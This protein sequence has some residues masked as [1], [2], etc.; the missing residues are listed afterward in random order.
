[1][2]QVI[3][4][5]FFLSGTN[6]TLNRI[7]G[8][9]NEMRIHLQAQRLLLQ[10]KHAF[11]QLDLLLPDFC[12]RANTPHQQEIGDQQDEEK[13]EPNKNQKPRLPP[14]R[15]QHF[16]LKNNRFSL[17]ESI[18]IYGTYPKTVLPGIDV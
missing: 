8:I 14:E 5:L 7:Q 9:K 1:L 17:G 16:K 6:Q 12:L 13:S 2:S 3:A 18:L 11:F 15:C 10:F 4:G